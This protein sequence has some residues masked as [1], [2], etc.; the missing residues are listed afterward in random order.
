MG[1]PADVAAVAAAHHERLDGRG[2]HRGVD[3][4]A[5]PLDARVL[6]A[7]DVFEAL[8]ADRPYRGALSTDEALV[9]MA[10]DVG[11]AFDAEVFAALGVAVAEST[12]VPRA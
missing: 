7:A 3:A 10:R 4:A 5:L 1:W 12:P 6:T 2:Y 8:T 9:T 11:S